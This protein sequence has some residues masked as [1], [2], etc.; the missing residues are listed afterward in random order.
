MSEENDAQQWEYVQ[1]DDLI[2]KPTFPSS[3]KAGYVEEAVDIWAKESREKFTDL[4]NN[5]N[6]VLHK[7]NLSET[8]LSEEKDR[9]SNLTE[10][11]QRLMSN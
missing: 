8:E 1:P 5:F 3:A 7:Y 11:N 2:A 4:A 6:I 9:V 10:A